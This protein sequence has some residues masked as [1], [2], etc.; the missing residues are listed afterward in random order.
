MSTERF[1]HNHLKVD[2]RKAIGIIDKIRFREIAF[3]QLNY[4]LF[5]KEIRNQ[6]RNVNNEKN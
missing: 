3:E 6:C 2:I 4:Q 5:Y 1:L